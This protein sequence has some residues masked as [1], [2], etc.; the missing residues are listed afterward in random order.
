MG[1]GLAVN[2]T[3]RYPRRV[4]KEFP[5]FLGVF[6]IQILTPDGQLLRQ[7]LNGSWCAHLETP[8]SSINQYRLLV[9]PVQI[10]KQKS[11]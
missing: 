11:F 5:I 4:S 9:G 1:L 10:P 2:L 7:L 8:L 3:Q 6:F